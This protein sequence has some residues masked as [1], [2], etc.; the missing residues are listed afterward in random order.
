MQYEGI[1]GYWHLINYKNTINNWHLTTTQWNNSRKFLL[2]GVIFLWGLFWFGFLGFLMD[3]FQTPILPE[4]ST[5]EE[6]EEQFE[7]FCR[8]SGMY[9]LFFWSIILHSFIS[10][11]PLP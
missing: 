1:I 3:M 10:H 4:P 9:Y 5:L 7:V 11:L 8:K 6:S 2:L